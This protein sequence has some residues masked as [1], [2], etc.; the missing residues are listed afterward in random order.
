MFWKYLKTRRSRE[1]YFYSSR[2]NSDVSDFTTIRCYKMMAGVQKDPHLIFDPKKEQRFHFVE[3]YEFHF[4][5]PPNQPY[6]KDYLLYF[7]LT[8]ILT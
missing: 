8:T 3:A 1:N 4:I 5:K 6:G 7:N 2:M